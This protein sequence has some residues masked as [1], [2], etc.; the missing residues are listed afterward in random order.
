MNYIITP[1]TKK[2]TLPKRG[3]YQK[4][5]TSEDIGIISSFLAFNFVGYE[6]KTGVKIDD[7]LGNYFGNNL[8]VWV[9]LFQATNNLKVDGCIGSITL[10]KMKEYGL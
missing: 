9:K 1:T 2:I 4:G 10:N 8:L 7:M 5:D 3:Y 6:T